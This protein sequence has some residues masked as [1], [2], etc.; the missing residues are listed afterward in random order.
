[1]AVGKK[2]LLLAAAI[3]ANALPAAF[4][5]AA[6]QAWDV[7]VVGKWRPIWQALFLQLTT[8]QALDLRE[9]SLLPA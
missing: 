9:S 8:I 2:V 3:C 5:D 7:I 6:Q 1:M 4:T